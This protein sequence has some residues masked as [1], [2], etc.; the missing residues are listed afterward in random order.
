[1]PMVKRAPA[2]RIIYCRGETNAICIVRRCH[3]FALKY[4]PADAD[5]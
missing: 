2:F 1:M 4:K 3:A 5:R